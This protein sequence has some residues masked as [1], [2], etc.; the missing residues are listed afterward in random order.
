MSGETGRPA[1]VIAR[2]K[3]GL[4]NQLFCYA[5]ARRL[6][7]VRDAQLAIDHTSGFVRDHK[8]RRQYALGHFRIPC[9][10]A[11]AWERLEPLEH[12][13][14]GIARRL[15]RRRPFPERSYVEDEW[16]GFDE[17]LLRL[18]PRGT[19]RLDGY[20]QSERFFADV[21]ATL[22]QDL[23]IIPPTDERNRAMAAAIRSGPAVA[24]HVRWFQPNLPGVAIDD[25]R[26]YYTRAVRHLETTVPGCR[27]YLFSDDPTAART[28]VP[29]PGERVTLVSHNDLEDL[30]YADLWL[31]SLCNHCITANS[32]FSWWGA[33]LGERPGQVVVTP[34]IVINSSPGRWGSPDMIPERWIRL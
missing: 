4:G 31:M 10:L 23:A 33:W 15:S 12:I 22:R 20:W 26:D 25:S 13:R 16:H 28:L 2:I 11:T 14:R 18:V 29:L 27:Y 30:A 34:G 8:Y 32:T 6:A 21:A 5:A 19:V 24:V 3:G 7:L 1:T 9:R 17:R